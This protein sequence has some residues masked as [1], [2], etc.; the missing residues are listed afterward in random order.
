MRKKLH[1]RNLSWVK[2]P[3]IKTPWVNPPENT[4]AIL[5]VASNVARLFFFGGVIS[6]PIF[7]ASKG[8]QI[9]L[10]VPVPR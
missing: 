1:Q 2:A 4:G 10:I 3:W 7:Q 5:K 6:R 9:S 8:V